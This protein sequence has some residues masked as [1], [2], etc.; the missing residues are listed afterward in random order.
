M[1]LLILC[2]NFF[3]Y[4]KIKKKKNFFFFSSEFISIKKSYKNSENSEKITRT[5]LFFKSSI[6]RFESEGFRFDFTKMEIEIHHL[7]IQ[8]LL[9]FQV[10]KIFLINSDYKFFM[11]SLFIAEMS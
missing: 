10:L 4:L 11:L 2:G 9:H 3:F 6:F 7:Q 8:L 1:E 5:D